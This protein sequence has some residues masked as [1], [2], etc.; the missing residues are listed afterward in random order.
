VPRT[1]LAGAVAVLVAV[2]AVIAAVVT[3]G[4]APGR[5]PQAAS[6]VQARTGA[7]A[8]PGFADPG[9][10]PPA[11]RPA[12][13]ANAPVVVAPVPSAPVEVE[14]PAIGVRSSLADLHLD[15]QGALETPEDFGMAGWFVDGPQPGQP[16][17]AVIAGHVDSRDGPAI[18]HRLRDVLP[19]DEVLVHR[20]DGSAVSFTVTGREQYAKDAFP[21]ASVY[22]PVPG[23][24][25]RLITCGGVFDPRVR[26]YRDNIV[27]YATLTSA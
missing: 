16:G 24:E 2:A 15:A 6:V 4:G 11:E 1:R 8:G 25:L 22:G 20:E 23:P 19:G 3:G 27:V 26:S 17:P 21:G 7:G 13:P 18:F 14:I 10:A 9:E 12:R 5:S